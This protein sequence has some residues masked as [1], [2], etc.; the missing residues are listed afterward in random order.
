MPLPRLPHGAGRG[1]PSAGRPAGR[2]DALAGRFQQRLVRPCTEGHSSTKHG[3]DVPIAVRPHTEG[4]QAPL[5]CSPIRWSGFVRTRREGFHDEGGFV[6]PPFWGRPFGRPG[7]ASGPPRL[8]EGNR[9]CGIG[10][11]GLENGAGNRRRHIPNRRTS[12]SRNVPF[13][14]RFPAPG[15]G[16]NPR[17]RFQHP[18]VVAVPSHP[19]VSARS[20]VPVARRIRLNPPAARWARPRLDRAAGPCKLRIVR[21]RPPPLIAAR[22]LCRQV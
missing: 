4:T 9:R 3:V 10:S 18:N 2:G 5:L 16:F 14:S 7:H 17:V 21:H 12:P 20:R 6:Q 11:G 22:S 15:V 19:G 13:S 8:E 1:L